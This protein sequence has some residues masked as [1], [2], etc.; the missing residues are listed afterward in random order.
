[1]VAGRGLN[2]RPSGYEPKV[3]VSDNLMRYSRPGGYRLPI[4]PDLL[5]A[6]SA[7]I[8]W[9]FPIVHNR[10]RSSVRAAMRR[11]TSTR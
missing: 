8:K 5:D 10:V 3:L 4:P 1:M 2:L 11:D 9:T 6:N 7:L